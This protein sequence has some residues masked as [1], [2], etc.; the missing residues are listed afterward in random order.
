MKSHDKSFKPFAAFTRSKPDCRQTALE[1]AKSLAVRQYPKA[2]SMTAQEYRK[3]T[4]V[5]QL[6]SAFETI[7]PLGWGRM[8]RIE[9]GQTMENWPEGNHSTLAGLRGYRWRSLQR[10][11]HRRR[12]V[13]E[14]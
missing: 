11:H 3:R 10:S 8:D 1:F 12:H 2:Y 9:V 5:E 13:G 7:V 4:T 14:W 6:R